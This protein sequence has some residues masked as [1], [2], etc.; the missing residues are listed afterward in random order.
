[1]RDFEHRRAVNVLQARLYQGAEPI[2]ESAY[3][4]WWSPF[5]WYGVVETK[6]FFATTLVD[7]AIP[8]V[9]PDGRMQIHYKPE[10]TAV[11]LAAK[12]SYL[13]RVYFDWAQYPLVEAEKL[14]TPQDGYNVRFQDLRYA[15]PGRVGNALRASV[16]LGTGLEVQNMTFGAKPQPD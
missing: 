16:R 13:G 6:N 8:E 10:E 3:P 4:Y 2:R 5:R 9:D 1:V 15:Y 11:T 14:E 12:R 7:S